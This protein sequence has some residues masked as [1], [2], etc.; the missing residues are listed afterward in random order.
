MARAESSRCHII[1]T[2]TRNAET[3]DNDA[4]QRIICQYRARIQFIASALLHSWNHLKTPKG[5]SIRDGGGGGGGLWDHHSKGAPATTSHDRGGWLTQFPEKAMNT[6]LRDEHFGGVPFAVGQNAGFPVRVAQ[7]GV[8]QMVNPL[9]YTCDDR[10]RTK[11][12]VNQLQ[13]PC[14]P[15]LSIVTCRADFHYG[16]GVKQPI[17]CILFYGLF[18]AWVKAGDWSN[19][20]V[21]LDSV[22]LCGILN[23]RYAIFSIPHDSFSTTDCP[24][25]AQH[26]LSEK[27]KQQGIR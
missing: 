12:L 19:I 3:E 8:G 21:L 7:I 4:K 15:H 22:S 25:T 11:T 23:F 16:S 13:K 9:L 2:R 1:I 27:K 18:L 5:T 6:S 10:E 14:W 20:L 26:G 17:L 24:T